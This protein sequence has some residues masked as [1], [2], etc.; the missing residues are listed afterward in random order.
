MK[1]IILAAGRGKRMGTLTKNLPKCRTI[2]N[3]KELIQ[4]QIDALK[5][6]GIND[7]AIVRGYLA[8]TFDFNCKYFDNKRWAETNMVM[9]L[10]AAKEWLCNYDCIS[11]YSDIIYSS[12]AVSRLINSSS[13]IAITYDPNW[14]TLWNLRFNDPLSDAET[15]KVRN[16]ILS[17]IGNRALSENEIEGQYMGLIKYSKKGWVLI[18]NHL[19]RFSEHELY[20][21]D[22]TTLLQSLIDAGIKVNAIPIKDNW[23]EIDSESDL[24]KYNSINN[25]APIT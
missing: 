22:M 3:G 9:S 6:A 17:E 23:Y 16:N 13:D 14:K 4:W 2:F 20:K 1:G 24:K 15:F 11:S 10:L 19:S 5:K 21:M 25:I 7:I 18:N 8:N 12:N